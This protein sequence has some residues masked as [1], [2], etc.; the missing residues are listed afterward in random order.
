MNGGK[1]QALFFKKK[2]RRVDFPT[3]LHDAHIREIVH[4]CVHTHS[5]NLDSES[6]L[7]VL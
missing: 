7:T 4:V 5:T 2:T 1:F 6:L 3:T